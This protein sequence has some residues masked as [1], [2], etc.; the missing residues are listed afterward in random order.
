MKKALRIGYNQYFEDKAFEKHL[1]FIKENLSLIDELALFAEC[2]H[3]GY[4]DLESEKQKVVVIE[5]RIKQYRAAGV[6][7]VGI[8]LLS[9]IG[10]LEEAWGV[11]PRAPFQ[12]Q[13]NESGVES[14]GCLCPAN[15]DFLEHTAK[16]YALYAGIGADFIWMDDDIRPDNHGVVSP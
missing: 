9:T 5:D 3:Y 8:N 12:Y 15:K 2:S 14:K 11:F 7:S 16:R 10:H 4:R 1:A 13:V 6:K